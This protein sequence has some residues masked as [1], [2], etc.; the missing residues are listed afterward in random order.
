[1]EK[2]GPKYISIGPAIS[3][4]AISVIAT[5]P[6]VTEGSVT[7]GVFAFTRTGSTAS[8]LTVYFTISGTAT[9]GGDYDSLGSSVTFA[10]GASTVNKTVNPRPDRSHER[11]ESVILPAIP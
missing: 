7:K 5:N 6:V 11:N 4:S 2:S 10:A 8:A 1:L 3:P 9:P